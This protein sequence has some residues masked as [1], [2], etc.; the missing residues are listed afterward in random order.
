[1]EPSTEVGSQFSISLSDWLLCLMSYMMINLAQVS[2]PR[3][4]V[5]IDG[6]QEDYPSS[7]AGGTLSEFGKSVPN[8]GPAVLGGPRNA[9]WDALL[10][11]NGKHS[12]SQKR[13]WT[14]FPRECQRKYGPA[15]HPPPQYLPPY[16]DLITCLEVSCREGHRP[17]Q[18]CFCSST[19]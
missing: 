14:L 8:Q 10:E 19:P 12:R 5:R 16:I 7:R 3:Q 4:Q 9:V 6:I 15:V 11:I 2:P 18:R 17:T 1:M 13:K